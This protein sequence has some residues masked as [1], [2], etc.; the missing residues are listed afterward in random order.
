MGWQAPGAQPE[1]QC[2]KVIA[3][4]CLWVVAL[5]LSLHLLP[6]ML[7]SSSHLRASSPQLSPLPCD[8]FQ[9]V[10][11]NAKVYPMQNYLFLISPSFL[12]LYFSSCLT[13]QIPRKRN[14]QLLC[15]QLFFPV[16]LHSPLFSSLACHTCLLRITKLSVQSSVFLLL[17]NLLAFRKNGTWHC[18]PSLFRSLLSFACR[19]DTLKFLWFILYMSF[20]GSSFFSCTHIWSIPRICSLL[21]PLLFPYFLP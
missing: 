1:G 18:G 5:Q 13:H 21:A 7:A 2:F 15:P 6:L 8:P 20:S 14:L 19:N 9:I 12:S 17:L 16:P 11:K 10:C 4:W 3:S